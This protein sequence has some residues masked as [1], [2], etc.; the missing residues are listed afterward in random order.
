MYTPQGVT[1]TASAIVRA[2]ASL[3]WV[4][5]LLQAWL[6]I[7]LSIT[8]GRGWLGGLV[9][10]LG[11]FTIL[12]NIFVAAVLTAHAVPH[13]PGRP[14][15]GL[16]RPALFTSATAA[17]IV[18][19]LVY[20]LV[21]RHVWSLEGLQWL[22]DVLLHYVMPVVTVGAWWLVVPRGSVWLRDLPVCVLFP[23]TYLVYVFGRGE[24]LGEYPYFFIDVT[25][26]GYPR[27]LLVSF[28]ILA[29]FVALCSALIA[30]KGG[31]PVAHSGRLR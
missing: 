10:Y 31:T 11:F 25:T 9:L 28:G 6:T 8:R 19:G 26:V 13:A 30:I 27:A 16:R 3:G 4:A 15:R 2:G 17:I 23:L 7:D 20:V 24:W 1:Q 18:V 21:L 12:T 5:L 29:G 22:A 14:G